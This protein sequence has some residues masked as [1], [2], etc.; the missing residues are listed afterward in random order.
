MLPIPA[1]V[2]PFLFLFIFFFFFN[3]FSLL[4]A[5]YPV[6]FVQVIRLQ[7]DAADNA[8]ARGR[9]HLHLSRAEEEVEAGLDGRGIAL[10]VDDELGAVGAVRDGAGSDVPVGRLALG[11]VGGQL[12]A[13]EAVIGRARCRTSA[14]IAPGSPSTDLL[15]FNGLQEVYVWATANGRAA[16]RSAADLMYDG[17][18]SEWTEYFL[19][20]DIE[21]AG[22]SRQQTNEYEQRKRTRSVQGGHQHRP[23]I[24]SHSPLTQL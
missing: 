14:Q 21:V 1:S 15:C 12:G 16:A 2:K 22:L 3:F 20:R 17:M 11:E 24:N 4:A 18:V 7:H 13:V 9:L 6:Y 19:T 23:G 10:L 5:T 8:R